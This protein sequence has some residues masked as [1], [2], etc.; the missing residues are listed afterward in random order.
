[1]KERISPKEWI[2]LSSY[3]D[4][5]LNPREKAR[6][7][8]RLQAE[9]EL[10]DALESLR[11]TKEVLRRAPVRRAPRNFTLPASMAQAR[12]SPT[13]RL[14][15]ALRLSSA[16]AALA[17]VFLMVS[18]LM[19]GFSFGAQMAASPA[20]QMAKESAPML[21]EPQLAQEVEGSPPPVVYWGGPP[22]PLQAYGMG[23]A[24]GAGCPDGRCGGDGTGI[25]PGG[26]GGGDGGYVPPPMV[27]ATQP[28]EALKMVQPT[29]VPPLMPVPTSAPEIEQPAQPLSGSGP[30][31]GVAPSDQQGEVLPETNRQVLPVVAAGEPAR[32]D[33]YALLTP[34][35]YLGVGL[36]VLAAGL[37]LAAWIIRRNALR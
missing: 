8:A 36:L 7:E 5:E 6:V 19:G 20:D 1:M 21:G 26:M 12:P 33:R 18:T 30:I 4:D 28:A 22:Q 23:G 11:R 35:G 14:V 17:A 31:L 16:V 29:S 15:P 27:M 34:F 32:K 13:L 2:L 9:A 10:R 25:V 3:L 24:G 37:F